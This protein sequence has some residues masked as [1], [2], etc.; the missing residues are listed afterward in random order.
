MDPRLRIVALLG[1][2]GQ[3]L[4]PLHQRVLL[5]S[6]RVLQS[7]AQRAVRVLHDAT[8]RA[9]NNTTRG[10]VHV[11][12]ELIIITTPLNPTRTYKP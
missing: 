4:K 5:L 3:H 6:T 10:R 7:P 8:R 9:G 12:K 1:H 11:E 2:M